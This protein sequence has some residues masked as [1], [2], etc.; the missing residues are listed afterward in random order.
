[1]SASQLQFSLRSDVFQEVSNQEFS[2]ISELRVQTH[3]IH[4]GYTI[5]S[6]LDDLYKPQSYSLCHTNCSKYFHTNGA[7]K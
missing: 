6:R 4:I 3:H 1:M 2:S 7:L 5:L